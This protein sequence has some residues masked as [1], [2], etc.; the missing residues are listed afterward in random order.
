MTWIQFVWVALVQ[1]AV[2][3]T[4]VGA[5][6]AIAAYFNGKHIKSGVKEIGEMIKGTNA[7][8]K[9][10]GEMVKGTNEMVKGTNEMITEMR[11]EFLELLERM[12]NRAEQRH[13]EVIEFLKSIKIK[14]A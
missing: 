12:E 6:I 14:T 11:K 7:M 10:I 1:T 4:F 3:A 13:S 5:G 8:L 9:E 2:M